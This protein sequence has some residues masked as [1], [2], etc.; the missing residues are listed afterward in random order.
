[1]SRPRATAPVCSGDTLPRCRR[2]SS[3]LPAFVDIGNH[4]IYWGA[5]GFHV[6]KLRL[7]SSLR[8]QGR[9]TDLRGI[10]DVFV[11]VADALHPAC[12]IEARCWPI[13]GFE[14]ELAPVGK[15]PA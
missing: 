12:P 1:M 9:D 15:G 11:S 4:V 5:V 7:G 6:D 10:E 2:N 3:A 13:G 14:V 8:E